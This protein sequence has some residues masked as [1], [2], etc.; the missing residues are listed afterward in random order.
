MRKW[1]TCA[2]PSA[3][4][5]DPMQSTERPTPDVAATPDAYEFVQELATDLARGPIDLPSFPSI[6]ASIRKALT[7]ERLTTS[8][9][10]RIVA[11]EPALAARV[12][13][14]ANSAG[15]MSSAGKRA[16]DLPAAVSRIGEDTVRSASIAFA[17]EQMK[18]AEDFKP[19]QA[20]LAA[21]WRRSVLL[22]ALGHVAALRFAPAK[23][24]AATLAG[25]LH[26][27]GKL[28]ILERAAR[29]PQLFAARRACQEIVNDW[30][31][32]V[33]KALLESWEM[34]EEIVTAVHEFGNP[35]RPQGDVASLTDLLV[36]ADLLAAYRHSPERLEIEPQ[37]MSA[38]DRL[39]ATREDCESVLRE[40]QE[41]VAELLTML[42]PLHVTNLKS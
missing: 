36:I 32:T 11:A 2:P 3:S 39:N 19:L 26:G 42:G 30:H 15:S 5:M 14:M 40:S 38:A 13:M 7:D 22:A 29:R 21:L 1:N 23:T 27:V 17:F 10:A 24:G 31:A 6:V 20:D 34:P 28:Y 4:E 18:K 33:A 8:G 12:L 16:G 35:E 41:E 37:V 25:L 9:I